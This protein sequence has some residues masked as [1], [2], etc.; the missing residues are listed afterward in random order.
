MAVEEVTHPDDM[1]ESTE[2]LKRMAAGELAEW[3]SEARYVRPDGEVRW[4]ALRALLVHDADGRSSHCLGL[5]RD[6][7]DQ[8]LAERRRAASHAVLSIMAT[9]ADLH[10]ALPALLRAVVEELDWDR[11]S[12]WLFGEDGEPALEAEWPRGSAGELATGRLVIPVVSGADDI[13]TLEFEAEPGEHAGDEL[14]AFAAMLGAQVGEFIV[15]KRAEALR[16]HEALHDPLTGLPNRALFLD[17][18]DHAIRRQQR[19]HAPL[20]V[21]FLDFD[22]F[23]AV[24]DRFG[25]AGGD[26]VLR[27]A[28]TAV[29]STLRS[30]D[31]VARFGGDELVVLSEHIADRRHV[32][33]IAERILARLET[34]IELD[35]ESV[36]LSASIGICLA[37][38]EGSSSD[39]L[40]DRADGAMYEA[41]AAGP[42]RYVIAGE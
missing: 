38:V 28:A 14:E 33:G 11:G 22:G 8:R 42:G 9:G 35:G 12:L 4:G 34:P 10:D 5:I 2:A 25:H 30:E 15:R 23:K 7:T 37:P 24:N 27:R 17:R 32:C 1:P 29:A 19:E 39:E 41:K 20:A 31:T 36:S 3:N 26:K 18:L 21:L 40:L 16:L 13:G 6:I